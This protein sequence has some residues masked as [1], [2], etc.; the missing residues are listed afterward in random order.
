VEDDSAVVWLRPE[1]AQGIFVDFATV[2]TS[3]RKKVPFGIAQIG[4]AFRNEITP[5][6][7]I[8]RTREFEQMELE[9]FVEPGTDEKWF[10][11]W[12]DTR[13]RWHLDFGLR[14][15]NVRLR[16]HGRDELAHYAKKAIDVEYRFPF[17]WSELEGIA[18][19]ADYD[20]SQHQR[21]SGKDLSYYDQERDTR[22]IP[23]VIEP[24]LGVDRAMLAF[25]IDA[26]HEDEAPTAK[27][28]TE[29]RTVLRLDKRLAPM[30][31]AVLPL[32][33]NERL[34]PLA[35]ELARDLRDRWMIDY[36]DAGAIGRRY[37]RQDEIGT[38]YAIT[39]DFDSLDDHAVTVRDRDTMAQER[40][41]TD[42]LS[43]YL[44]ERLPR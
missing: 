7:F 42:R 2:Q 17:G 10:D 40:V 11:E 14:P 41:G 44:D 28:G 13:Q 27:G 6:N 3:S 29:K 24:S 8:F 26:Y 31:A 15:G 16:E 25:L 9:F 37:R 35:R 5:G 33:R 43:A 1:T 23:Y 19:R 22:Y 38:P 34:V 39:V 20:L 36:D 12:V 4:K 21:F 30:K 18:N 32:S